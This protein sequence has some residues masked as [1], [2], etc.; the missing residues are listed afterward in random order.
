MLHHFMIFTFIPANAMASFTRNVQCLECLIMG[1][2]KV[3]I[4]F[5]KKKNKKTLRVHRSELLE[6]NEKKK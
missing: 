4:L 5:K 2:K 1:V 3:K 6:E